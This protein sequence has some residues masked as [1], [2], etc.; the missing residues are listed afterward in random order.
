MQ[1]ER[2]VEGAVRTERGAQRERIG[3]EGSGGLAG[4]ERVPAADLSWL[5]TNIDKFELGERYVLLAPGGATHR[6][7]KRWPVKKFAALAREQASDGIEPV[8]LGGPQERELA[9]TIRAECSDA[10]NLTGATSFADIVSLAQSAAGAVGND[11]GPMHLVAATGCPALVLFSGASDP[12]L[13]QPRGQGV[14]VLQS[15]NL[16]DLSVADVAAALRLR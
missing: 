8:V 13:T 9:E 10:R 7:D 4:I 1:A 6:P 14:S 12:A 3:V 15:E 16:A 5:S 11:T 2:L